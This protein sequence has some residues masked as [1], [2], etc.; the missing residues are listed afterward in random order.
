DLSDEQSQWI[1]RVQRQGGATGD[2]NVQVQ[3]VDVRGEMEPAA[4]HGLQEIGERP[5]PQMMVKLPKG[6]G[7]GEVLVGIAPFV[8]QEV[9]TLLNSPARVDLAQR[10]IDGQV[11]WVFLGSGDQTK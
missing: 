8:E 1:Q 7:G 5:L 10:L 6:I 3:V 4:Q 2:T 11:V 9:E